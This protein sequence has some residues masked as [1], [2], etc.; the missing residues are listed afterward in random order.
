M[1][2]VWHPLQSPVSMVPEVWSAGR[3]C[4]AGLAPPMYRLP[5]ADAWQVSQVVVTKACV[6]CVMFIGPKVPAVYV[7]VL[8]QEPQSVPARYGMCLGVSDPVYFG[9]KLT[10]Q[11]SAVAAPWHWPQLPLMP[12]CRTEFAASVAVV[13]SVVDV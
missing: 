12:V 7:V 5:A 4:S 11:V 8:W 3:S 1:A 2:V 13:K 6:A 9:V 10:A